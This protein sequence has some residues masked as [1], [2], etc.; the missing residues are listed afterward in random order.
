M[1]TGTAKY[2]TSKPKVTGRIIADTPK[3]SRILAI[4]DPTILPIMISSCLKN[5][6]VI[7]E[8]SSGREVP[9]ATIVS[10]MMNSETPNLWAMEEAALTK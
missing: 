1:S 10:P 4:F 7:D 5:E 6:A 8:A 9:T 3:I 2:S